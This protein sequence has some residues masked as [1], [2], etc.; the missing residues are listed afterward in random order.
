MV[1]QRDTHNRALQ[2]SRDVVKEG[3]L[4]VWIHGI[5]IAKAKADQSVALQL[6]EF[7]RDV[8]G[9]LYGLRFND[10]APD[11]D[12]SESHGAAGVRVIAVF[13]VPGFIG[14]G[15]PGFRFRGGEDAV[16][17]ALGGIE[18]VGKDPEV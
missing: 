11:G 8:C 4:L 13:D 2:F 14:Q 17:L 16:A 9:N 15:F 5:T 12:S 1:V 7:G 10:C 3:F 18:L 6:R